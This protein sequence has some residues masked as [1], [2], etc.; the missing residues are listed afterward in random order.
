[1]DYNSQPWSYEIVATTLD[2]TKRVLSNLTKEAAK[3]FYDQMN[4]V[5]DTYS[6]VIQCMSRKG[7]VKGQHES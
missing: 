7:V 3:E 6:S 2:G 4:S 1:M 5:P